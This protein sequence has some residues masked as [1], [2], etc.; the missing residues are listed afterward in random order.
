MGD[1][2][3]SMSILLGLM[4]AIFFYVLPSIE[5]VLSIKPMTHRVDNRKDHE[6]AKKVLWSHLVPLAMMSFLLVLVFTP[7]TVKIFKVTVNVLSSCDWKNS[8]F[9]TVA[10]V[11]VTVYLFLVIAFS[12]TLWLGY[13]LRLKLNELKPD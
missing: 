10:A 11:F 9:D 12:F 5:K 2:L 4:S 1:V 6:E 8:P 7:E 3:S 13:R